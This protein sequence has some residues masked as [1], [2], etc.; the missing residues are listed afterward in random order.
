[1]ENPNSR[2]VNDGVFFFF[3]STDLEFYDW[4]GGPSNDVQ[5][6]ISLKANKIR[7]KKTIANQ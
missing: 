1:M 5:F 2:P 7:I 3:I 6:H 4:G